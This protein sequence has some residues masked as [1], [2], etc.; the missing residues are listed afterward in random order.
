M[1]EMKAMREM[2]GVTS[3]SRMTRTGS[4]LRENKGLFLVSVVAQGAGWG[5]CS[6]VGGVFVV[7]TYCSKLV[8][9]MFPMSTRWRKDVTDV[10]EAM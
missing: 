4:S 7:V 1:R 5:V 9:W 10:L 8:S 2:R 3:Q 6:A